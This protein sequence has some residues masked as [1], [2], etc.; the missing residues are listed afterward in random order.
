MFSVSLDCPVLIAPSIFS[1][2]YL[3]DICII[4]GFLLCLIRIRILTNCMHILNL[5]QDDV[6]YTLQKKKR[7]M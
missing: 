1:Y 2:V 6:I 3:P 4:H 5:I 7:T